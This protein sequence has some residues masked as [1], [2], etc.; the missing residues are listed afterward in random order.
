MPSWILRHVIGGKRLTNSKSRHGNVSTSFLQRFLLFQSPMTSLGSP[1][2]ST[3]GLALGIKFGQIRR[4][5]KPHYWDMLQNITGLAFVLT[6]LFSTSGSGWMWYRFFSIYFIFL[7]VFC[8]VEVEG[9]VHVCLWILYILHFCLGFLGNKEIRLFCLNGTSCGIYHPPCLIIYVQ[10]RSSSF[11]FTYVVL[12][13]WGKCGK[14]IGKNF[15]PDNDIYI[16]P[17][18]E[19]GIT[20]ALSF[21]LESLGKIETDG[22]SLL[23]LNQVLLHFAGLLVLVQLSWHSMTLAMSSWK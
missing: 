9:T 16:L 5:S 23:Y 20:N 19:E 6:F 3:S 1:V 18:L 11:L 15:V 17:T 10:V 13:Y 8:Q 4:S 7:R 21:V 12:I 22:S 14:N 2:P